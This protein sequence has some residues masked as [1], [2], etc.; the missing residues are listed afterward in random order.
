MTREQWLERVARALAPAFKRLGKELPP[1][2]IGVGF[3]STGRP[4]RKRGG[5]LHGRVGECHPPESSGDG[6]HEIFIRPDQE[7]SVEVAAILAHELAH[8]AA[9]LEHRHGLEFRRVATGL[10]L[11][12]QMRS[13]AP[14]PEFR[15][16]ARPILKR[17]GEFPHARLSMGRAEIGDVPPKQ[18]TRLLLCECSKCGYK[19]RVSRVWIDDVGAPHCP[20]HGQMGVDR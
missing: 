14:G 1:Y 17:L 19:A 4:R 10:G 9:G 11:V 8:A 2:R 3:P 12:G 18:T 15:K 13:T 16:L 5:H 7:D 20:L 6:T